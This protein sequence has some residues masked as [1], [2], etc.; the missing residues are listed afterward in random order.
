MQLEDRIVSHSKVNTLESFASNLS[1]RRSRCVGAWAQV[2]VGPV[3]NIFLSSYEDYTT[4]SAQYNWLLNDLKS[5]DRT[6]TPW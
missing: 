5:I 3:H 4:G 2:D 1:P 6:K